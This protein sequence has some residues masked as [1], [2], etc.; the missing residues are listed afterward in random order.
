MVKVGGSEPNLINLA[1]GA[2]GG[3][4]EGGPRVSRKAV[5]AAMEQAPPSVP[6]LAVKYE[7]HLC[8]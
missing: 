5:M 8:P 4:E 3:D 2:W 6:A 1:D 7:R